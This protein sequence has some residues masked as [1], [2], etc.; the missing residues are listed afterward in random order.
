MEKRASERQDSRLRKTKRVVALCVFA[1]SARTCSSL[2][3]KPSISFSFRSR[4]CR[5][6]VARGLELNTVTTTQTGY[7]SKN[8]LLNVA[9]GYLELLSLVHSRSFK[10]LQASKKGIAKP[11]SPITG[12]Q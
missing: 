11:A 5:L 6:A 2:D 8:P 1:R 9:E 12:L 10:S 3:F 7:I 4:P